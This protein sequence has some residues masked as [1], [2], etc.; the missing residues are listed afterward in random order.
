[1]MNVDLYLTKLV[2]NNREY[3]MLYIQDEKDRYLTDL[4]GNISF[5]TKKEEAMLYA[6]TLNKT[7]IDDDIVFS[8]P[9]DQ[10]FL[11]NIDPIIALEFWNFF[12]DVA[13][14]VG[15]KFW[16]D[17]KEDSINNLYAKLFYANNL[18]SI[19]GNGELYIPE[20]KDHEK[21]LLQIIIDSGMQILTH[22]IELFEKR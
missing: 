6:E 5:F 20:W 22:Q 21:R 18:P 15:E 11:Q 12:S 19:R 8:Y 1:M 7:V 13:Y 16:G 17:E 10:C 2:Y 9:A 3:Y 4:N 14:S